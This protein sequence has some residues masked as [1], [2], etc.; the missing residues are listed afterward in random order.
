[1]NER[2]SN[3]EIELRNREIEI[4]K[5]EITNPFL[6]LS[7]KKY[8]EKIRG[9]IK[10]LRR[11]TRNENYKNILYKIDYGWIRNFHIHEFDEFGI[12]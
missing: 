5:T 11:Y 8:H 3:I 7:I 10:I 2:L 4:Q 1:M 12:N 6:I 9:K